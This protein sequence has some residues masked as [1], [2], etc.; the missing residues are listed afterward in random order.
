MRTW[1]SWLRTALMR[2]TGAGSTPAV[3]TSSKFSVGGNG[4]RP[5]Y[6]PTEVAEA[7]FAE[8]VDTT[9]RWSLR[10]SEATRLNGIGMGLHIGICIVA[11]W[12]IAGAFLPIIGP[13]YILLAVATAFPIQI[14]LYRLARN[15]LRENQ[16]EVSMK[17]A[18]APPSASG[19][20]L[21]AT[22]TEGG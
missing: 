20:T 12:G 18:A 21:E 10:L 1:R 17:E 14:A 11:F 3:R 4:N 5:P 13:F 2:Q 16:Q 8:M 7:M 15:K 9:L 19:G 6:I 22:T